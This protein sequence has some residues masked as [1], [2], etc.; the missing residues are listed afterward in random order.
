MQH[1]WQSECA[2]HGEVAD[3]EREI[4]KCQGGESIYEAP[5]QSDAVA[6][7]QGCVEE[8]EE[9]EDH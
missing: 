2:V 3:V 6:E 4:G 1:S 5:K 8:N 9:V 7:D